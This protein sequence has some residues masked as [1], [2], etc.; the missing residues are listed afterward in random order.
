MGGVSLILAR[1]SFLK[2]GNRVIIKVAK[3]YYLATIT[4][5]RQGRVYLQTDDEEKISFSESSRNI[6][7]EAKGNRTRKSPIPAERL[8]DYLVEPI[9]KTT[10]TAPS[11]T[12]VNRLRKT[13]NSRKSKSP[14]SRP[15][16]KQV[17][18]YNKRIDRPT[19]D[20]L[21]DL[22]HNRNN[23][24]K[25]IQALE[26]PIFKIISK[27]RSPMSR[28]EDKGI[29]DSNGYVYNTIAVDVVNGYSLN[30]ELEPYVKKEVMRD[31][32]AVTVFFKD[33]SVMFAS[34]INSLYRDS[35]K[36]N[37]VS[38]K[39]YKNRTSFKEKKKADLKV[40]PIVINIENILKP[41]TENAFNSL[42]E[43]DLW[44]DSKKKW[45]TVKPQIEIEVN[46]MSK[47]LDL[48]QPYVDSIIHLPP[49]HARSKNGFI[50]YFL[51]KNSGIIRAYPVD[52]PTGTIIYINPTEARNFLK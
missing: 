24:S 14:F 4:I 45:F 29:V 36:I 9:T 11:N 48:I 40:K 35:R 50:R 26:S 47:A 18:D 30:K 25:N 2:K 22:M 6:I 13:P 16:E 39:D 42:K 15:T 28:I 27:Y 10:Q 17:E 12:Q 49:R 8:N 5:L 19:G 23:V 43:I 44:S 37:Y 32:G 52:K 7:G 31:L 38:A 3:E 34:P 21:A 33:G 1:R 20:A 46:N 51:L 41:V